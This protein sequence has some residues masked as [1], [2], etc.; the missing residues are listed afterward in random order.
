MTQE[1]I[2]SKV[3]AIIMGLLGAGMMVWFG[4]LALRQSETIP[5]VVTPPAEEKVVVTV[6]KAEYQKGETVRISV[7]N[8]LAEA[9][10][11]G[12]CNQFNLAKK[13]NN[14]WVAEQPFKMCVWEGNAVKMNSK[15]IADYAFE[16]SKAGTFRVN[17]GYATGCEDKK[18]V[19]QAN[20]KTNDIAYSAEFAVVEAKQVAV[21]EEFLITLS[22]NPSTGYTWEPQFDKN[23]LSLRGKDFVSDKPSEP[24]MVGVGGTEVFTFAPI[25]VGET[26]VTMGYGR[27]WE[28]KPSETR[29]FKYIIKGESAVSGT[30]LKFE[31][32]LK[33]VNNANAETKTYVITTQAEW[34]QV[35][36]KTGAE[37]IAPID[38]SK[39]MAVAVF[40]GQKPTGGYGVEVTKILETKSE[41]VVYV[42]EVSPGFGCMVTQ[43]FTNPYHIVK[44]KKSAKE[45]LINVAKE[46]TDCGGIK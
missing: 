9:V 41:L 36:Q 1:L 17:V 32:I 29:V 10:F 12:G 22:A 33:G 18:P 25:K 24:G 39:D 37:L 31:T 40:E 8:N 2:K 27:S 16:A 23:Y 38:F 26:T 30:E 43:A 19:S 15:E 14:E 42:R 6:G 28:S 45:V 21:G 3:P 4:Y 11:F 35:F 5:P 20:C 34:M 46:I 7:K 44:F 13:E